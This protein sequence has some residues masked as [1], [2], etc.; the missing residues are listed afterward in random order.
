MIAASVAQMIILIRRRGE[1]NLSYAL[2][3]YIVR[4]VLPSL[5]YHAVG[6]DRI[7]SSVKRYEFS[8]LPFILGESLTVL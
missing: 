8:K 2:A 7:A 4:H 1:Q 6:L 3:S 5:N